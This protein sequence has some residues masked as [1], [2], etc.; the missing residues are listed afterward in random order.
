MPDND[1]MFLSLEPPGSC[2]ICPSWMPVVIL[3]LG[4]D[5]GN[6]VGGRVVTIG[7]MSGGMDECN[8]P[9]QFHY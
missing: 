1:K 3:C 8:R 5:Y 4:R 6:D 9:C 2:F 7:L